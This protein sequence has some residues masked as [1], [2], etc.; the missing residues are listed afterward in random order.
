MNPIILENL[1]VISGVVYIFL[2]LRQNNWCWPIGMLCVTGWFF[3]ALDGRLYMDA[4]LQLCYLGL[5]IYGWWQWLKG[6]TGKPITLRS[7][8]K[9]ELCCSLAT[10]AVLTPIFAMLTTHILNASL[11]WLDSFTT[12]MCLAAQWML[13]RKILENWLFWLVADSL[14]IYIY[15]DKGW[16]KLAGVM[17]VYSLL[18]IWG[19]ISWKKSLDTDATPPG[20]AQAL[21]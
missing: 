17:A 16:Y 20:K 5:S 14:Y 9:R 11:S 21:A 13:A 1:V 2:S 15:I 18:A 7:I 12:M 3:L 4:A 8:S 10:I 6:D 19:Y